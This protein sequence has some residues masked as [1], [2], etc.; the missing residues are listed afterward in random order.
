MLP[1]TGD[2]RTARAID[3]EIW[4]NRLGAKAEAD[5]AYQLDFDLKD[6]SHRAVNHNLRV[7]IAGQVA[8]IDHLVISAMLE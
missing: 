3:D 8:Q 6:S 5:A 7:D 1:K 4:S 2:D